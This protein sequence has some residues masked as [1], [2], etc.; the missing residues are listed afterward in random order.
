MSATASETVPLMDKEVALYQ[1]ADEAA[2]STTL[3]TAQHRTNVFETFIHLIKGYIGA[4]MLSLPWAFSCLGVSGGI[5][6]VC[7]LSW[8]TSYNCY[9]VV[10]IKRYMERQ[11]QPQNSAV[12]AVAL[13]DDRNSESSSNI[14]YPDVGTSI[15]LFLCD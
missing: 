10:S 12:A 15:S 2:S 7:I 14:T 1:S 11:Q 13:S 4:G 8:W 3:A 5:G 6:G 9:T